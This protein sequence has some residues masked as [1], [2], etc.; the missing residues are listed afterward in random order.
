MFDLEFD[1][2]VI[3]SLGDMR[4]SS[5]CNIMKMSLYSKQRKRGTIENIGTSETAFYRGR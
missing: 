3:L 2:S 4:E 1:F 5:Q